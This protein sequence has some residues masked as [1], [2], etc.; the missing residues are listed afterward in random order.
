MEFRLTWEGRLLATNSSNLSK[1]AR[2]DD[3]HKMRQEFHPQLKRFYE[4][5]PYLHTGKPSGRSFGGYVQTDPPKYD[6]ADVASHFTFHGFTFL[7]LVHKRA[8]TDVLVGYPLPS[9]QK[10]GRTFRA[11]RYRQSP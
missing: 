2:K 4:I 8:K 5:T 1:P 6:K 3:K 11:W 9:A 7:P 10:A